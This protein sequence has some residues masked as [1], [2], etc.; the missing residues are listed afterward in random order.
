MT[1]HNLD[2]APRTSWCNTCG[3]PV[4]IKTC[5]ECNRDVCKREIEMVRNSQN[6]IVGVCKTCAGDEEVV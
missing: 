4:E 5:N 1:Q 6:E 3:E 2:G